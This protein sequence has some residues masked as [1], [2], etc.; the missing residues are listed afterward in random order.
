MRRLFL[1]IA[2]AG[3]VNLVYAQSEDLKSAAGYVERMLGDE[4]LWR[5]DEQ[6]V[7][8]ALQ[9]LVYHYQEPFDSVGPRLKTYEY[10]SIAFEYTPFVAYESRRLFWLNDSSFVW[11]LPLM[12][13]EPYYWDTTII[14]QDVELGILFGDTLPPVET[15]MDSLFMDPDTMYAQHIDSSY[16]GELGLEIFEYE[17]ASLESLL[18]PD[19]SN[20]AAFFNKDSSSVVFADTSWALVASEQSPFRIL[21]DSS[22][23]DSLQL[24]VNRLLAYTMERDSIPLYINDINGR[25][26]PMWLTSGDENMYRYWV[27]NYKND[28]ITIWVG[29]PSRNNLSVVLEEDVNIDRLSKQVVH[30][31]PFTL[32]VPETNLVELKPLKTIPVFWDT[33]VS[34]SFSFSQ[35]K[36][37]DYWAKGGQ[38]SITTLLDLKGEANYNDPKNKT[39]WL[40]SGRLKYGSIYTRENGMRKSTDIFEIN[41]KYNR[42][43]RGKFDFSSTFYMKNQIAG[44]FKYPTDTTSVKVSKFLNPATFTIGM[45]LEYKPWKHTQLNM[46]PLSYKNT[47]VLD[48]VEIDQTIHGI[49]ADRRAKQELGTQVV[50]KS[51]LDIYKGIMMDNS[52]RLF[53]SYFDNPMSVDVDWEVNLKKQ[54]TW[55]FTVSANFHTIYDRDVLFTILDDEGNALLDTEGNKVKEPR[56]Q[57]MQFVGLSFSFNF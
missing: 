27:K 53:A 15:L 44:G 4:D 38:S 49:D 32:A 50:M 34:S 5:E 28:S 33:K 39:Q 24:A 45:G 47:F 26:T 1:A 8:D 56:L 42:V 23:S 17:G 11:K 18:L 12:D 9:R 55:F 7:R 13:R 36:L 10:D 30:D 20:R 2:L 22:F 29:N 6:G 21:P 31:V 19:S 3:L 40:N 16:L 51:K 46:A 48:T 14:E 37:S 35:T 43:L 52:L 41:S 25:T 54:V 57:F